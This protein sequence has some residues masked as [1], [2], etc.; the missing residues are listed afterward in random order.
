[1]K[2][3]QTKRSPKKKSTTPS[4]EEINPC[5]FCGGKSKLNNNPWGIYIE[6]GNKRCGAV[7]PNTI[8]M[9]ASY[10]IKMWNKRQ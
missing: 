3:P 10:A 9:T 7:G 2:T 4:H 6:C 8:D 5:P 1:M